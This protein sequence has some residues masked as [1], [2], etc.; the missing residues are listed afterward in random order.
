MTQEQ[1]ADA[2]EIHVTYLSGIERGK[3]NPTIG[4]LNA[5]AGALGVGTLELLQSAD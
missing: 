5:V 1:L 2:A 4:M 3:K